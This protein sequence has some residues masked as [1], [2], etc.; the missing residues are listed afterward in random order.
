MYLNLFSAACCLI[1][2]FC[3]AGF[4][5]LQTHRLNE[6]EAEYAALYNEVM[7]LKQK[8]ID[9]AK[10]FLEAQKQAEQDMQAAKQKVKD[11]MNE[12][13]PSDCS[14]VIKWGIKQAKV[15]V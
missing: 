15:L 10:Q 8:S 5:V 2:V 4:S 1:I 12:K 3:F 7:Q 9:D 14:D 11:I 6:S 13:V